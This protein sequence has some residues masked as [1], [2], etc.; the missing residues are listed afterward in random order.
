VNERTV[1]GLP[2]IFLKKRAN[3]EL[4]LDIRCSACRRAAPNASECAEQALSERQPALLQSSDR[5]RAGLYGAQ[6]W[7]LTAQLVE[8]T[9]QGWSMYL[10]CLFGW[11]SGPSR[12]DTGRVR[13]FACFFQRPFTRNGHI[14]CLWGSLWRLFGS[15]TGEN[16]TER[17]C[18]M[19]EK[20]MGWF[21]WSVVAI[22]A[23]RFGCTCVLSC[24]P[25]GQMRRVFWHIKVSRRGQERV[26]SSQMVTTAR[27]CVCGRAWLRLERDCATMS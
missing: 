27:S 22:V 15:N 11:S 21:W 25:S 17:S 24:I 1:S 4:K 19:Y 7:P 12:V 16:C 6:K 5:P 2:R 9:A 23:L 10:F 20:V 26:T 13:S 8:K 3:L 14:F 18:S